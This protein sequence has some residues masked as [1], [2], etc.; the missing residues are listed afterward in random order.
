MYQGDSNEQ[1][2]IS[3]YDFLEILQEEYFCVLIR[4]K[5]YP[6]K[7]DKRYHKNILTR[8]EDKIKK[9]G[10][11]TR[12][13]TIFDDDEVWM[14]YHHKVVPDTGFPNMIYNK[15]VIKEYKQRITQDNFPYSGTMVKVE[16]A[17]I[18]VTDY[19]DFETESVY[20]QMETGEKSIPFDYREVT[21]LSPQE[22]DK[23]FY[24]LPGNEFKVK[25]NPESD[26]EV[27]ILT[28]VDLEKEEAV[29]NVK[30]GEETF[31]FN[32]ISRIL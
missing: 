1:R 11:Q 22:T 6:R 19:V 31:N 23:L 30:Q 18:G 9:I 26:P 5:V 12:L 13:V 4:T 3:A 8:K 20:V 25:E 7:S 2:H 28:T 16:G 27:G 24:Y 32:Q 10:E 17:G 21:R 14:K 15:K 29:I